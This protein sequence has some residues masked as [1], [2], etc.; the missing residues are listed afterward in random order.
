MKKYVLDLDIEADARILSERL[1]ICQEAIDFFRASSS[2]LKAGVRAGLSL[3]DIAIRCCRNDNL[4]EVPS[5]LEKLVEMASD[6]SS[7]ALENER[8]DHT[9]ASRAIADQLS[10]RH[11]R[12]SSM[13]SRLSSAS[14]GSG[15][16][17]ITKSTSSVEFLALTRDSEVRSSLSEALAHRDSPAMA[18]SSASDSSTDAADG[19][20]EIADEKEEC[21]CWAASII[22]DVSVDQLA[23]AHRGARSGSIVSDES[24]DSGLSCSPKGFWHVRPDS[25]PV[26]EDDDGSLCWS[27]NN[28]SPRSSLAINSD[29]P[30]SLL[31]QSSEFKAPTVSF[32]PTVTAP[33][34]FIAPKALAASA[35]K[36]NDVDRADNDNIPS[37]Y[38][39]ESGMS[40]SKSYSALSDA[41]SKKAALV[42]SSNPAV[43]QRAATAENYETFR[44]YFNKF[45]DLV[46]VREISAASNIAKTAEVLNWSSHGF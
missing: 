20:G 43:S 27:S 13:L 34:P 22:M 3:Y 19:D 14:S 29:S 12:R 18:Q 37:L 46:I 2:I 10:P 45:I 16:A 5:M 8:W 9:A 41:V 38:R 6:L 23:L 30:D 24:S 36:E 40:R 26:P 39:S 11:P 42:S 31:E 32:A 21:E 17:S 35:F 44:K 33:G 4:A 1:N 25:S 28:D 7:A 15:R